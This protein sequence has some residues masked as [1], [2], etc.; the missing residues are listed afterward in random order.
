MVV[1]WILK[2]HLCNK[3]TRCMTVLCMFLLSKEEH[4]SCVK[5]TSVTYIADVT[6]MPKMVGQVRIHPEVPAV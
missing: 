5:V 2:I 6:E 3:C 1:R 4:M